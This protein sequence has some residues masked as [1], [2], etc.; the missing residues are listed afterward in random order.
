MIYHKTVSTIVALATP[1]GKSAI[2]IIRLSGEKSLEIAKRLTGKTDFKP[3]YANLQRIYDPQTAEIIDEVVLTY[4]PAPKSFTGEDVIEISCH[5]APIVIRQILDACLLLGARIAEPG[6]FSLRAL[7]NGKM[8]LTQV[9]AI[10]D[11]IEAQ[12][13]AAAR[14]SLRQMQGEISNRLQPLKNKLLD[15]IVILESALEFVEDDLPEYQAEGIKANLVEIISD[16]EKMVSTFK[17]GRLLR[18]GLKVALAGRPNVGKSSL[19]NALVGYERAIVT[20]IA[21]TTRDSISE[22]FSIE[23]IPISLIDTAGLRETEDLVESIGVERTRKTLADADLVLVVLDSSEYLMQDDR[24][25]LKEAE[26]LCH[27]AVVNK[28]DIKKFDLKE[29]LLSSGRKVVEVSAKTG[30]GLEALK[31]AIL[32]PFQQYELDDKGFLITNARHADLLQRAKD[33]LERSLELFESGASEEIVLVGLHNAMKF[34]GQI[35]GEV[36]TEDMLSRIFSTFCI[37]K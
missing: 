36:T 13:L 32:E 10:R 23:G 11:L 31:K 21:G 22:E 18:Q 25:I 9:E 28:I 14:Q 15:V 1:L 17:A 37:G 35:T 7:M 24:E 33:E 20:S 29:E 8:N 16:L 5:G 6:E 30:E 26:S 4:F 2:A 34:L 12:T 27:L 3:R 19:F